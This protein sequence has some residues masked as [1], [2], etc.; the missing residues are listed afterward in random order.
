MRNLPKNSYYDD[1][2]VY[3]EDYICLAFRGTDEVADW[4]DNINAFSKKELFGEFHR[5]FWKSVEDVWQP[6]M[7]RLEVCQV[8]KTP[9]VLHRPQLRWRNGDNSRSQ[10]YSTGPSF[11]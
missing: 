1:C 9:F 11:H 4:L 3:Y 6:L 7:E 8:K 10:V 5:G 2:H